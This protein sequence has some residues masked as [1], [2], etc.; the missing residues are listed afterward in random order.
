MLELLEMA[1]RELSN[2]ERR[3]PYAS[4]VQRMSV[5]GKEK[6]LRRFSERVVKENYTETPRPSI[7]AT[8][9]CVELAPI[10]TDVRSPTPRAV[11]GEI[12]TLT[13]VYSSSLVP[14]R[15][16]LVI[17]HKSRIYVGTLI[18]DDPVK[19]KRAYSLLQLHVNETIKEIGDLEIT[20]NF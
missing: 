9:G 20:D 10:W 7:S 18:F 15:C 6:Q 19:C 8:S 2:L 3:A 14:S 11:A 5:Q 1:H 12:G 4:D 17:E 16:Y 13:Y